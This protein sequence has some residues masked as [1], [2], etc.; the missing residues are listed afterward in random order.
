MFPKVFITGPFDFFHEFRI[1]EFVILIVVSRWA[2][3]FSIDD[4]EVV[5]V[6]VGGIFV[7]PARAD[8]ALAVLGV[9]AIAP[10]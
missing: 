1:Y 8:S 6:D 7:E 5:R 9:S 4:D 3:P 2:D 10:A